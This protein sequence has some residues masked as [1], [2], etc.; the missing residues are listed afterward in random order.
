VTL[1]TAPVSGERMNIVFIEDPKQPINKKK[2]TPISDRCED[3]VYVKEHNLKI[4][5]LYYL[6]NQLRKPLCQFLG[7]FTD[8]PE[9]IFDEIEGDYIKKRIGQRNITNF[10]TSNKK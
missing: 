4:D 10:F 9:K 5:K 7:V 6:N 1:G 2:W 8:S 3:P